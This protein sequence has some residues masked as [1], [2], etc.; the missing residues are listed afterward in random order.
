MS[1]VP[2]VMTQRVRHALSFLFVPGDRPERFSRATASGADVVVLDLEDGVGP[3]AKETA[4]RLVADHLGQGLLAAVRVN[5]PGTPGH[6]ADVR[7]C[8]AYGAVVMVPK[9]VPG[10]ALGALSEFGIIALVET[11]QGVLEA[12]TIARAPGVLRL[13]LG[14]LDLA[15]ELG[16][17]G[18]DRPAID[19]CRTALVLA[20]AAAGLPGPVDGVTTAIRDR[21]VLAE[22]LAHARGLGMTG[23]LC[24]HPDQVEPSRTALGPSQ[25]QVG[26]ARR[27]LDAARDGAVAVLDDRMVDRPVVERA[28]RILRSA[29]DTTPTSKGQ[30]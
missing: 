26:W 13:A 10:P 5:P 4:R 24:I 3:D 12:P 22:D 16:V 19:P 9:A 7:M 6:E 1:P 18:E 23:K 25:E 29:T 14:H 21:A 20:S 2:S 28:R 11:A 8:A 30:S 27:V 15:A 17:D